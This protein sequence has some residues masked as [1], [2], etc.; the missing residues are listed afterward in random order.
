MARPSKLT[1]AQWATI[2]RRLLSGDTARALGREFDVSEGA[3]RKRFGAYQS[4]GA[5]STQVRNAAEKLAEANI[6]IEALTPAQR[7]IAVELAEVLRNTSIS[8][9]RA[10]EL[11]A[12]TSHRL[13]AIVNAQVSKIDE[14]NPTADAELL[15]GMHALT[16]LAN[17]AATIPLGLL[18]ANRDAVKALNE[19]QPEDELLTPERQK[20]GLRRIVYLLH[21]HSKKDTVD[22]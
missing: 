7:P 17:G 3:I 9:G 14:T 12:K 5:Q 19:A 16:K 21:K 4:I 1:P 8:L 2:E 20:E 6:A 15:N 18:S 13:T 22:G 11:S 10:A